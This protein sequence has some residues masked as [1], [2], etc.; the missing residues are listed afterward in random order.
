MGELS[1]FF[2]MLY[3]VLSL[4]KTTDSWRLGD[5]QLC[6]WPGPNLAINYG[7]PRPTRHN[8]QGCGWM[9]MDLESG[10]F[11]RQLH[12]IH[13]IMIYI[14]YVTLLW[15]GL[16]HHCQNCWQLL[17]TSMVGFLL[18][19][20]AGRMFWSQKNL[21]SWQ[22]SSSMWICQ[23]FSHLTASKSSNPATVMLAGVN[24]VR[25]Q[26]RVMRYVYLTFFGHRKQCESHFF[27]LGVAQKDS[28]NFQ[29]LFQH[30]M[31]FRNPGKYNP[32][33]RIIMGKTW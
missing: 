26:C 17:I 22:I 3:L 10:A 9:R 24:W 31:R 27:F 21:P 12:I 14:H 7:Q 25:L 30:T 18:Y 4:S 2:D 28:G 13:N 8:K 6:T 29:H 32:S 15:L 33:M 20:F 16:L 23:G 1:I 19:Y 5:C 11:E